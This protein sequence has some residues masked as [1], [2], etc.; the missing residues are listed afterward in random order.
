M[1]DIYTIEVIK[2]GK[3]MELTALEKYVNGIYSFL[4]AMEPGAKIPVKNLAEPETID[5]FRAVVKMYIDEAPW[6]Y[7][8]FTG[9]YE[10]IRRIRA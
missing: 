5:L 6:P 2:Y 1:N 8:E 7:I 4:M 3:L 10:S 9:N